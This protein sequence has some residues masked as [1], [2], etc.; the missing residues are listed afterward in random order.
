MTPKRVQRTRTY[1]WRAGPAIIVDRSSRYGNP[2]RIIDDTLLLAPDGTTQRLATPAE[3]R[4]E[5]TARFRAW[6]Q[7]E[8]VDNW[9]VCRKVFSRRRVLTDLWRLKNRDLACTCPLPEEG[10]PDHC[11]A[12]VLMEFSAHPERLVR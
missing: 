12:R 9:Q 1:G 6:L 8:G 11:H 3:A 5:A 7:G 4:K 10:E 2:W